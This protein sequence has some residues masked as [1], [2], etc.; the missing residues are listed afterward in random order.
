MSR[1]TAWPRII[2]FHWDSIIFNL[3]LFWYLKLGSLTA[4]ELMG[5]YLSAPRA[6]NPSCCPNVLAKP[7]SSQKCE[8]PEE[9]K[10]PGALDKEWH[11]NIRHEY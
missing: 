11:P 10:T 4:N 8:E 5:K 3:F 6:Q 1:C 9:I 2:S 7:E